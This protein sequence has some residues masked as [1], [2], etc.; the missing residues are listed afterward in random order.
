ME[1]YNF[2][3][4]IRV[5]I[6]IFFHEEEVGNI[7]LCPFLSR[8]DGADAGWINHGA[9][10]GGFSFQPGKRKEFSIS[11]DEGFRGFSPAAGHFSSAPGE[12]A[13][14]QAG[15]IL[16]FKE[17]FYLP[18]Q[19]SDCHIVISGKFWEDFWDGTMPCVVFKFR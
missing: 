15:S 1:P 18:A 10:E 13:V 6:H 7:V 16:F 5:S 4:E 14:F 12:N 9:F 3:G 11:S 17:V 8:R 19:F 2:R